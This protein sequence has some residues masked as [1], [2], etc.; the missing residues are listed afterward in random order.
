VR[1]YLLIA[2]DEADMFLAGDPRENRAPG[3]PF[4]LAIR[5]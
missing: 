5:L 4:G 3:F 1:S 2:Q